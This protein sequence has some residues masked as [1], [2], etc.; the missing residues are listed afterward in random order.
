VAVDQLKGFLYRCDVC[1][2]TNYHEQRNSAGHYWEST[3]S[4][5]ATISLIV[6]DHGDRDQMY[7][8]QKL[9]CPHHAEPAIELGKRLTG[10]G[11]GA[12]A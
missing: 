5:W 10:W 3:P 9:L 7:V 12:G 6:P 2:C 11:L 1:G 4:G 8:H